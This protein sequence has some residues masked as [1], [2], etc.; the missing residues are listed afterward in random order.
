MGRP[1]RKP[2]I[3]TSQP[4]RQRCNA[5]A[6][7]SRRPVRRKIT[8][9]FVE[10]RGNQRK[11]GKAVSTTEG[12]DIYVPRNKVNLRANIWYRGMRRRSGVSTVTG[13][14]T[15]IHATHHRGSGR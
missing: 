2:V 8:S 11:H 6:L 5:L 4:Y 9:V 15:N 7:E 10:I 12:F 3:P 13:M 1:G 14:A